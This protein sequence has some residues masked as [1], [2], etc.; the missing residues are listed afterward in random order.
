MVVQD[1]DA[2]RAKS[3]LL[4][5]LLERIETSSCLPLHINSVG[6]FLSYSLNCWTT[7]IYFYFSGFVEEGNKING[8]Q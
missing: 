4:V 6:F 7:N 2:T 3:R 8:A 5:S 1:T